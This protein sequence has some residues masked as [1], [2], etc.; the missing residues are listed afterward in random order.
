MLL[1]VCQVPVH[2]LGRR[3]DGALGGNFHLAHETCVAR[4]DRS[5]PPRQAG[6]GAYCGAGSTFST[7]S[8]PVIWNKRRVAGVGSRMMRVCPSAF[9]FFW[10]ETNRDSPVESMKIRSP[11]S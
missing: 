11:A 9:T 4:S 3:I 8:N 2:G 1:Q 7:S 6:T 5:F 10:S